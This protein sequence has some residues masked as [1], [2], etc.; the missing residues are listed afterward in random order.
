[1][2]VTMDGFR[3]LTSD[4][5]RRISYGAKQRDRSRSIS[6]C[7]TKYQSRKRILES[8]NHGHL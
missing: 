4:E 2:I 5:W 3:A 8:Q 1:M 6:N 7:T